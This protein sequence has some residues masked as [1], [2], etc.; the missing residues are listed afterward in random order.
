MS[1]PIYHYRFVFFP[2]DYYCKWKNF[3]GL[4]KRPGAV[5]TLSRIARLSIAGLDLQSVSAEAG[6]AVR[7]VNV[8]ALPLVAGSSKYVG[9][10]PYPFRLHSIKAIQNS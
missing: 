6:N 1:V 7:L 10:C 4:P 9:Q 3:E 5:E 2:G 8:T